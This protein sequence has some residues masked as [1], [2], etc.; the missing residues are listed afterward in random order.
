MS[1]E[2]AIRQDSVDTDLTLT[3]TVTNVPVGATISDA[4]F[5]VRA[6]P[7]DPAHLMQLAI[8]ATQTS[9]GVITDTDPNDGLATLRF[10]IAD[11]DI[12]TAKL[13]AGIRYRYDVWVKASNAA[14]WQAF[15]GSYGFN[16]PRITQGV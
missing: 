9:A 12:E 14:E 2:R 3:L 16:Y 7:S 8:T 4:W 15:R 6:E 13:L 1:I 5:T 11:T 10:D